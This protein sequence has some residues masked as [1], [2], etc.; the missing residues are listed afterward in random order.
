MRISMS[1][2]PGSYWN[3]VISAMARGGLESTEAT[4]L[5]S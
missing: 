3:L 5:L 1:L 4:I 2:S